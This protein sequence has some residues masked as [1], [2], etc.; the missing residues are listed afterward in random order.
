MMDVGV[1]RGTQCQKR[2]QGPD[3]TTG[4]FVQETLGGLP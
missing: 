1:S 4:D 2:M 3:F